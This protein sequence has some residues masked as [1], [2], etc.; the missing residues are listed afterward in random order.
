M[1]TNE[2]NE[3][4]IR[5]IVNSI[6]ERREF[7]ESKGQNPLVEAIGRIWEAIQEWVRELL[8]NRNHNRGFQFNPELYSSP[9]QTILK[10]L[11]VLIAVVLLFF[12]IRLLIKRVYLPHKIKKSQI[13]RVYDYLENPNQAMGKFNS[14]MAAKEYSNAF[15]LLF[16]AVLLELNKRKI[17]K[18]EKWK[19]NRIYMREISLADAALASP[20]QEFS[21]L[22]NACCYG[23]KTIDEASVNKW[24]DF[25]NK[26]KAEA[27]QD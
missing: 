27:L 20:M 6:L 18:I 24:L 7:Q 11:L 4:K 23:D 2:I 21:T 16:I 3:Q 13:P 10:I 12:L 25:Y 9:L 5:E 19:T 22:F 1:Q 14:H 26:Q 15:R 8:K 17:I